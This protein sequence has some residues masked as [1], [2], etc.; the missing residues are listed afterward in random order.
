MHDV[1]QQAVYALA[2]HN[3]VAREVAILCATVVVYLL[4]LA[5]LA[6]VARQ[7]ARL[8]LETAGHVVVLGVLAYLL[9]KVLGHLIVDPR[10]YLV[11]HVRPLIPVA[12]DN[13]FPSDHT[14]LAAVLTASLWW[15]DRRLLPAFAVGTALVLLGRLGI[16]AHHTID[17][18]GSVSIATVAA[19][20]SLRVRLP[21]AW[22]RP[23]LPALRHATD[24]IVRPIVRRGPPT[25]EP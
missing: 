10:P 7:Q 4:V 12:H 5:W 2:S 3:V 24:E 21:T 1:I 13:G 23:L 17:V 18:L 22:N 11:E 8:T 20:V 15:I 25:A 14:L 6:V 19:L 16:A 9:A